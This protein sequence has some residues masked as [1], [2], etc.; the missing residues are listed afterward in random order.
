MERSDVEKTTEQPKQKRE[1]FH[2]KKNY[3]DSMHTVRTGTN[4]NIII[5]ENFCSKSYPK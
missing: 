2:F 4:T 3:D 5:Y 1:I